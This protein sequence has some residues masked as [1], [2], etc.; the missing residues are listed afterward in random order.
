MEQTLKSEEH[1]EA[2]PPPSGSGRIPTETKFFSRKI[3]GKT[4]TP[5]DITLL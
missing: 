5:I 2:Q 1:C 3:S 4:N